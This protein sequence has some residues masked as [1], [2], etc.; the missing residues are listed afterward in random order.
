MKILKMIGLLAV[1]AAAMTVFATTASATTATSPKGTT[2]TGAIVAEGEGHSTLH[3]ANGI[4]VSCPGA[5]SA[6]VGT[7]GAGMTLELTVTGLVLGTAGAPCTNSDVVHVTTLGEL[8]IHNISGTENGTV[9]SIGTT[10]NVTDNTGVSCGYVTSS[11]DIGTLTAGSP[12]TLDLNSAKI[13]RHSGSILCGSTGTWTG[14][15]KVTTPG[16]LFIDA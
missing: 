11:T 1:A 3:G 13:A 8:E 14:S 2:Y 4:S 5:V 7:H 9:T 12:A 10:V 6:G 15:Y 16:S